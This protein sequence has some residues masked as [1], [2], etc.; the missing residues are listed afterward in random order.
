MTANN[1]KWVMDWFE[2]RMSD[3]TPASVRGQAIVLYLPFSTDIEVLRRCAN[4]L[5]DE[6]R[7]RA[8]LFKT[9][10]G[11]SRFIQRRAFRRYCA[12]LAGDTNQKL[13]QIQFLESSKGRPFLPER[14]DLWFSFSS[15]ATGGLGA[16]SPSHAIGVD[17]EG[18][19]QNVEA[20]EL[21]QEFFTNA[22]AAKLER[23]EPLERDRTFLRYWSLKEAAL[24][25]IGEGLPFG[26][27]AFELQ[28]DPEIRVL[29][30]PTDPS[31][32][33]AHFVSVPNNSAAVVVK[34]I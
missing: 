30:A 6:E 13:S 4:V 32:F 18:E 33:S 17:I 25:S 5:S 16:W 29:Q 1:E 15:C 14:A 21:A 19:R 27:D 24:K 26:M 23:L 9:D 31:R 12:F 2:G 34:R 10:D 7:Q 11:K 28:L 8:D 3:C 20:I 22:E